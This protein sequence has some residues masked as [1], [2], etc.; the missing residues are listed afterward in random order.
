MFKIEPTHFSIF[1]CTQDAHHI[2]CFQKY[3]A[4][5]NKTN[6]VG[7][8]VDRYDCAIVC[9]NGDNVGSISRL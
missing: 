6:A 7:D 1:F 3:N 5:A 4:P 9:A 2:Q 8:E